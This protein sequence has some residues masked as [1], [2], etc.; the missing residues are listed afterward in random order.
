MKAPAMVILTRTEVS[1][2]LTLADCIDA[3]EEAFRVYAEG[4]A[5]A[6]GLLHIDSPPG[7]FHIKAGGLRLDRTYCH[8]PYTLIILC[9]RDI[10]VD[11]P[12][13]VQSH[14]LGFGC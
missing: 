14:G 10:I 4:M 2:L 1:S 11:I 8:R 12:S 9:H 6:P 7:E 3:V 5:L 13:S